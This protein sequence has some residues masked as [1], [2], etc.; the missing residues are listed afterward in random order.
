MI[1]NYYWTLSEFI[2]FLMYVLFKYYA[3]SFDFQYYKTYKMVYSIDSMHLNY[4]HVYY[5][6]F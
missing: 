6:D 3:Y 1:R 5:A 2:Y 4:G